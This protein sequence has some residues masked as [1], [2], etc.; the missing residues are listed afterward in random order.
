[1]ADRAGDEEPRRKI[2][3]A[4]KAKIAAPTSS[5]RGRASQSHKQ[6]FDPGA[7]LDAEEQTQRTIK[8]LY[9]QIAQLTVER[10]FY[11]P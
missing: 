9:A 10:N 8:K 2:D 3:A 7:S 4:L 5:A 1:V 11:Y 6:A